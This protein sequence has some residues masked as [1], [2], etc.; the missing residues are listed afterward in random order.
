MNYYYHFNKCTLKYICIYTGGLKV[1]YACQY[2]IYLFDKYTKY[3]T[4]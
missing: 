1:S 3:T 2:F 4:I